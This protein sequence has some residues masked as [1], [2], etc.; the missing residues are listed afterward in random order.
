MPPP[1]E[2]LIKPDIIDGVSRGIADKLI[3]YIYKTEV[4]GDQTGLN[5]AMELIHDGYGIVLMYN[6][7]SKYEGMVLTGQ[8]L[9]NPEFR[10]YPSVFPI[11]L[12]QYEDQKFRVNLVAALSRGNLV[13]IVTPD[14]IADEKYLNQG[15]TLGDGTPLYFRL[16][17]ESLSV[18]GTVGA[19]PQGK[20]DRWLD[21][22][23]IPPAIGAIMVRALHKK[24][25][26][27]AFLAVGMDLKD[28]PHP[29]DYNDYHDIKLREHIPTVQYGRCVTLEELGYDWSMHKTKGELDFLRDL[30][31]WALYELGSVVHE[32]YL[33]PGFTMED[34]PLLKQPDLL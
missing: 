1:Q 26:K 31:V 2:Q 3:Q 30:S 29:A 10:K 18:G 27:I 5:R 4:I 14:T 8:L 28:I 22:S 12:H 9:R 17:A 23:S 15:V 7:F 33:P 32:D 6:H 34:Q 24:T 19:A 21:V 13:P 25:D 20:R 11:G 16:A